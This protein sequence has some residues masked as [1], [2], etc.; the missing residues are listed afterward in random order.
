MTK[1]RDAVD[2]WRTLCP[3]SR[4]LGI[5]GLDQLFTIAKAADFDANCNLVP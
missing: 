5:A 2:G 1:I 3:L 4:M